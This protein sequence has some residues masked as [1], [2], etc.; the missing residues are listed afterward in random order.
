MKNNKNK[1]KIIKISKNMNYISKC[2]YSPKSINKNNYK[3]TLK[4][5]SNYSIMTESFP[6]NQNVINNLNNISIISNDDI[7]VLAPIKNNNIINFEKLPEDRKKL[8]YVNQSPQNLKKKQ[9]VDNSKALT[10]PPSPKKNKNDNNKNVNAFHQQKINFEEHIINNNLEVI[11]PNFDQDFSSIE[12]IEQNQIFNNIN[13]T[14][15][16]QN[17][18]NIVFQPFEQTKETNQNQIFQQ[19]IE[20]ITQ[21]NFE[22]NYKNEIFFH[23]NNT[24]IINN[25]ITL[26]EKYLAKKKEIEILKN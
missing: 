23:Q 12:P 20:V 19:P 24:P 15:D 22:D 5:E 9:K 1:Q 26:N 10:E 8:K 3:S 18:N 25:E 17:F 21:N 11:N 13:N 14:I 2:N 6:L 16:N 4:N 7:L